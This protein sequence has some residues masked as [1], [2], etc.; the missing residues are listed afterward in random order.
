MFS[1]A[2]PRYPHLA[3]AGRLRPF[4]THSPANIAASELLLLVLAGASAAIAAAFLKLGL[5][6]PGHVILY[7]T[8]PI[9]FGFSL[10]PRRGSGVIMAAAAAIAGLSLNLAGAGKQPGAALPGA[11]LTGLVALGILV[12]F[13]A[14]R[15]AGGWRW[16]LLF[17]ACGAGANL[18]AFAVR[19]AAAYFGFDED[20]SRNFLGFWPGALGSYVGCGLAAGLLSAAAC[21][22]ASGPEEN[23]RTGKLAS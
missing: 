6:V 18:I 20:T 3:N 19:F 16:Y 2:L 10:S 4:A 15:N 11:A 14:S 8:L 5:R 22:R 23:G 7:M 17:A 9:A 13:A 21:F 1:T 12:D